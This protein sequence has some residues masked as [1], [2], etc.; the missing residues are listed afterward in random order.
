LSRLLSFRSLIVILLLLSVDGRDSLRAQEADGLSLPVLTNQA[1]SLL[2]SDPHAA[3]LL[4]LYISRRYPTDVN[5]KRQLGYIYYQKKEYA[6]AMNFFN[7]AEYLTH[8]DTVTLQIAFCLNSLGRTGEAKEILQRL[9]SSPDPDIRRLAERQLNEPAA[10]TRQSRWWTRIYTDPY[11]DTRWKSLF[12]FA[13]IERGYAVDRKG[14]LNGYAFLNVS[15]D[16]RSSDGLIPE[17]FSDNAV[18]AGLGVS[19][20]PLHGLQFNTQYG[21][22]YDFVKRTDR[23]RVSDDFRTILIYN[24]GIY[25][26]LNL[27]GDVRIPLSLLFDVYTSLG[28]YSRF[29]NG[30][31]YFQTRAGARIF[32]SGYWAAD[33][34]IKGSVV[35]DI[36]KEFYNNQIDGAA[37]LRMMPDVRWGLCLAAEFHRGCYWDAGTSYNPYDRYFSS[38][39][40]FLIFERK[41]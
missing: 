15:G 34:Y 29:K 11:Y 31:G 40:F 35:R 14:I 20:R 30:I 33:I 9:E 6:A 2:Q 28:Y 17:I 36:E 4:F 3:E 10:D 23:N 13:N 26:G 22:S 18:V 32:E 12:Y 37:G 19:V 27:H 1:Y 25:P 38:F 16:S 8:S 21:I 41:F 5:V 7:A 39:R 24:N